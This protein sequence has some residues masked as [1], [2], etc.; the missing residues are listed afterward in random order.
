M[1]YAYV[2]NAGDSPSMH[3]RISPLSPSES[4]YV[5]VSRLADKPVASIKTLFTYWFDTAYWYRPCVI[6]LDNLDR[7]LSAEVEVGPPPSSKKFIIHSLFFWR[8]TQTLSAPGTSRSSFSTYMGKKSAPSSL[9]PRGLSFS[10]QH[11]RGRRS[12]PSS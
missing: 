5:D 9:T 11:H 10:P 2:F 4:H 12:T 1:L 6:I 8:S 3:A 7:L